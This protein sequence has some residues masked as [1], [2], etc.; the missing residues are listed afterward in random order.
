[1]KTIITAILITVVI[2]TADAQ[3][4]GEW[5][6]QKKT[7]KKY[8]LQ[9][10]AALKIYMEYAKEGYSIAKSGIGTIKSIKKG[11]FDLH[12]DYFSS[13][14][15][16][17]PGVRKYP[18]IKTII[19]R[20]ESLI[21]L[22]DQTKVELKKAQILQNAEMDFVNKVF[23]K[24]LTDNDASLIELEMVITDGQVEMTDDQRIKKIGQICSEV[25]E[26]YSVAKRFCTDWL[27]LA[28]S[29]LKAIEE[30]DGIRIVNG[31]KQ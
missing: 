26:Q 9:Q 6:N 23:Q 22:V 3:T 25:N 5:S 14:K 16:I 17:N 12:T 10:I 2:S 18:E 28:N 1:M 4:W 19:R 27:N 31:I 29:R 24:I 15:H 21:K 7:Q 20:S 30:I 11:D 13:L 8:L